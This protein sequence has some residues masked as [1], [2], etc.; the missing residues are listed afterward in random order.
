MVS[1]LL[2]IRG[3]RAVSHRLLRHR[4]RRSTAPVLGVAIALKWCLIFKSLLIRYLIVLAII[5]HWTSIISRIWRSIV[6]SILVLVLSRVGIVSHIGR[7]SI[8]WIDSIGDSLVVRWAVDALKFELCLGTANSAPCIFRLF[9]SDHWKAQKWRASPLQ[10]CYSRKITIGIDE[11]PIEMVVHPKISPKSART[12]KIIAGVE[13]KNFVRLTD[14]FGQFTRLEMISTWFF[15]TN[16]L[17]T[18][19]LII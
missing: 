10:N 13:V 5:R 1:C 14:R 11:P 7:L 2:I 6:S 12:L 16:D 3:V 9:K 19:Y 15:F 17:A 4:I 18:S 8:D